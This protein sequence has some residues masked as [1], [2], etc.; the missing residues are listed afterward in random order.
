MFI[1]DSLLHYH[2]FGGMDVGAGS[3][4]EYVGA[5]DTPTPDG[6]TPLDKE[7]TVRKSKIKNYY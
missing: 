5:L 6:S 7:F 4:V 1:Y 3:L 2:L